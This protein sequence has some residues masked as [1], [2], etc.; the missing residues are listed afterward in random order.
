LRVDLDRFSRDLDVAD[1]VFQTGAASAQRS[2]RFR[3]VSPR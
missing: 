2:R 1:V 3:P